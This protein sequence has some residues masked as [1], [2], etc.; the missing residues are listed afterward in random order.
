MSKLQT[1]G[2]ST[3]TITSKFWNPQQAQLANFSLHQ[4][5]APKVL[6]N[7][8]LGIWK[9]S[10]CH[11]VRQTTLSV[12]I[13]YSRNLVERNLVIASTSEWDLSTRTCASHDTWYLQEGVFNS[14]PAVPEQV[15]M[16]E[17]TLI[18]SEKCFAPGRCK[19]RRCRCYFDAC[20]LGWFYFLLL[21]LMTVAAAMD[22]T[23]L[24]WYCSTLRVLWGLCYYCCCIASYSRKC[25]FPTW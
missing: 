4:L 2:C 1:L 8:P 9:R 22:T 5:S 20:L 21:Y 16:K 12:I 14:V 7:D 24:W 13:E 10:Q 19:R 17:M 15:I 3:L 25:V 6:D 18:M 23:I 11:R